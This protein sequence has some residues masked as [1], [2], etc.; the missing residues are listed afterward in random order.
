MKPLKNV[1]FNTL[2]MIWENTG[3]VNWDRLVTMRPRTVNDKVLLHEMV[4]GYIADVLTGENS[5]LRVAPYSSEKGIEVN[6]INDQGAVFY[7]ID[8][9][10]QITVSLEATAN[11]AGV[12]ETR[13]EDDYDTF[14]ASDF[15]KQDHFGYQSTADDLYNE[16]FDAVIEREDREEYEDERDEE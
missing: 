6:S 9:W 8:T 15:E 10:P 16:A 12:A 1:D 14:H 11:G 13:E 3:S 2:Y 7:N 5:P 4:A